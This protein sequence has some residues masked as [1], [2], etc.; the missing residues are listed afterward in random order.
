M[1]FNPNRTGG[2][3]MLSHKL[4][5]YLDWIDKKTQK[6]DRENHIQPLQTRNHQTNE[7]NK[8]EAVC[9]SLP[10]INFINYLVFITN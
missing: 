7:P 4:K 2:E 8:T 3:T 6:I 10:K 5:I 1:F 9:N